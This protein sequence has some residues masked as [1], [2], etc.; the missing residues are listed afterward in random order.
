MSSSNPF[1]GVKRRINECAEVLGLDDS[2][3]EVLS[4]P[5]REVKA[6][7]SIRMDDGSV[8]VFEAFRVLYN[9]AL[10]PGKGGIRF[11]PDE[12]VDTVRALAA[13]MT[14]KTALLGLP[15]GGAKGGVVCDPRKLSER[16]LERIS[17]A[18]IQAMR[19]V[20]GPDKDIPAPDV[21][22]DQ[23]VMSWMMDEY[24]RLTGAAAPGVITGKPVVL[25]GSPGRSDATA[26][27]G[28]YVLEEACK[29]LDV[30][31]CGARVAVQGFGNVGSN[32][33]ALSVSILGSKVVAVSDSEGGIYNEDGLD[34]SSVREHKSGSGS[35]SG[36][37]GADDITNEELLAL[38]V[39]V[40]MLAALENSITGDN[41]GDVSADLIL[42]LAN[43]PS[44]MEADDILQDKG[45]HLIPDF[46]ANAGGA[47]VSH[48]EMTQNVTG[49]RWDEETV[50]DRLKKKM[51]TAYRE[52]LSASKKHD[53]PARLAAY[54]VSVERVVSAMRFRGRV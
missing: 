16:E 51:K 9:N 22:T 37:Q 6:G 47:T 25:G 8:R 42:E 21:Y 24:E 49:Q 30:A 27:G 14:W 20:I 43:G 34:I 38:D 40:L 35:V 15:L 53:V 13:W 4:T 44:T 39:D 3:R 12:T 32:A 5:M 45:V 7:L 33:A 17:R 54:I 19:D 26:R 1:D 28:I 48:F 31:A 10:G 46:L 41:A 2:V 29:G 18:Y 36:F 11:H 23:R 50:H 52:V